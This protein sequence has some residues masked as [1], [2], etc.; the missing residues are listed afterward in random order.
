LFTQIASGQSPFIAI[1]QQGGQ[2]KD[3]MGGIG[4]MFRAIGTLITPFTVGITAA[5]AAVG[6]LAYSFYK[7]GDQSAELRDNLILTG[8]FAGTTQSQV[9]YFSD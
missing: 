3:V 5:A 6:A 2:L 1:I 7:A 4:P 9:A 8:N